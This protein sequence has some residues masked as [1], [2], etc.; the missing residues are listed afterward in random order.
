MWLP[1]ENGYCRELSLA[2]VVGG[3]SALYVHMTGCGE[4][5]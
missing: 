3:E 1:V 5:P 4:Q 2:E